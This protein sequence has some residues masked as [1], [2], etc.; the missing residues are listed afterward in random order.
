MSSAINNPRF[1]LLGLMQLPGK[2]S[3]EQKATFFSCCNCCMS[4]VIN[5]QPFSPVLLLKLP[6]EQCIQQSVILTFKMLLQ[7]LG[8][9]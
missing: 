6:A 7:L 9:H 5:E 2:Q 8:E 4:S 1:T 3:L